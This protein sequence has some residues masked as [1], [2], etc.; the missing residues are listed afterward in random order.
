M[1]SAVPP[2]PFPRFPW[3]WAAGVLLAAF[4]AFAGTLSYPFVH[5]DLTVIG[6]NPIVQERGRAL[7]AF[8]TDYWAMRKGDEKRDRLYRPLTVLTLALNHAL[9][10][11]GPAGYRL[12]NVLLHALASLLLLWA[13]L[14]S[15]L[16]PHAAGAVALL[17]ALH[18]IHTEAVNAVVARADLMAAAGVFAG[19][20]LLLGRALP[21][22]GETGEGAAPGRKGKK[23]E[24]PAPPP[25]R[26]AVLGAGA[27]GVFLLAL[28][29]KEA[30]AALLLWAGGWWLW[31]RL[32]GWRRGSGAPALAAWAGL[33]AALLLYLAMRYAALG[34]WARPVPPSRLDNSLAH[35]GLLEQW[36][37]AL[38]VLGRFLKLLA[39][40]WPL[41]LDYSYA[42]V[43][44]G[45][46][47]TALYAAAGLAAMAGWGWLAWRRREEA[48]WLGLGLVL[49]LAGYLPAANLLVPIGTVM[50]ERTMYL[51]SAGFLLA[52][53]PSMALGLA[54]LA[55]G[56]WR[57][58]AGA[59]AAAALLLGG[60]AWARNRD[61]ADPLRLWGRAA[62][63]SPRSARALATY[64][65]YLN[66]KGRFAE[67]I[68]P[69]R[70][71][72]RI[73]PLYDPAWIDLGIAQ[74]QTRHEK[75]AEVSLKEAL[76]LRSDSPEA[77]LALGALYSGTGRLEEAQGH[78]E[79]AVAL[80]PHFAESRFNLGT[81]YLKL[82]QRKLAIAQLTA[83]LSLEPGRGDAHHN[84]AI[85]L[86]LERDEA[87]ARRHA[88][89]AS[90]LGVRLHPAMAKA[91]G[92]APAP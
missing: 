42:Q 33:G 26:A 46:M 24:A 1:P 6:A 81:L 82:G 64:G 48:P 69:L 30:G 56:D 28:L 59:L 60:L 45:G 7:D 63:V 87:G 65:Q 8:H 55:R 51:P 52:A 39:W 22:P 12:L 50:A 62:E 77:H 18:P 29:S 70:E 11:E 3:L 27:G 57:L 31:C 34:M 89:E 44:P 71:A 15:G 91:L 58:P 41:S 9:G 37:G 20:A 61:W 84:L 4:A 67:A 14:R 43:L 25:A 40:P 10:G 73:Y 75:E 83:A 72:A 23:S 36:W 32:A 21:P 86:Y 66:R 19:M 47:E 88:R 90:R 85:A 68:P 78:L 92:L 17:F 49:F 79:R 53:V 54:R 5:D 74:M 2:D 38:G 80:A 76:R 16:G 13:A 35:A